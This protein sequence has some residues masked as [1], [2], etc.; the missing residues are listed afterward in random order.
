[1]SG[2]FPFFSSS[3]WSFFLFSPRPP[4]PPSS[5]RFLLLERSTWWRKP[6]SILRE[7]DAPRHR[8]V[9]VGVVAEEKVE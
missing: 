4:L 2:R 8:N 6:A 1:M 5:L 7:V 9:P 3:T